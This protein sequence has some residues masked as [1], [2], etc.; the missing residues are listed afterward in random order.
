MGGRV[1]CSLHCGGVWWCAAL[2]LESHSPQQSSENQLQ[3]ISSNLIWL[4]KHVWNPSSESDKNAAP[5]C[6]EAGLLT[7]WW[8]SVSSSSDGLGLSALWCSNVVTSAHLCPPPP[9][10]SLFSVF[11][12]HDDECVILFFSPFFCFGIFFLPLNFFFLWS[13]SFFFQS[14]LH[15]SSPLPSP[16]PFLTQ[17][18]T[19][20]SAA[21]HPDGIHPLLPSFGN[22]AATQ[23]SGTALEHSGTLMKTG[24]PGACKV[25]SGVSR[26]QSQSNRKSILSESGPSLPG[27]LSVSRQWV[28]KR[29]LCGEREAGQCSPSLKDADTWKVFSHSSGFSFYFIF[30][31]S[32]DSVEGRKKRPLC[33]PPASFFRVCT[34]VTEVMCWSVNMFFHIFFVYVMF[35]CYFYYCIIVIND[36]I[37]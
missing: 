19:K 18:H 7:L 6:G 24:P 12:Q 29:R 14:F 32:A 2:S 35:H 17:T 27:F 16:P 4:Q 26:K 10:L 34:F 9:S 8:E 23:P 33:P 5:P 3:L 31:K 30:F 20:S 15:L 13:C 28:R 22:C 36:M 25:A 37:I 1:V 21:R 11:T